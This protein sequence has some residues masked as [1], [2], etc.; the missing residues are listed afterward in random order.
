MKSHYLP[1]S[2]HPPEKQDKKY[3]VE[4]THVWSFNDPNTFLFY[5]QLHF[6]VN[7]TTKHVFNI[8]MIKRLPLRRAYNCPDTL[9]LH[10]FYS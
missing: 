1:S 5:Y 8:R 7:F 6:Q 10:S 3:C 9:N 2:P 4:P